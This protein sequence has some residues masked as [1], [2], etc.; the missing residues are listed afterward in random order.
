[1]TLVFSPYSP[2]DPDTKARHD[3]AYKTWVGSGIRIYP[4]IGGQTSREMGDPHALPFV[5]DLIWSAF[6]NHPD[7]IVIITNNDVRF[8]PNLVNAVEES[9]ER[10]GAYWAYRVNDAGSTDGGIDLFGFSRWW[11][12]LNWVVYPDMVIG[13]RAWDY[14]M[15]DIMV[16]SGVEEGV[17]AYYHTPHSNNHQQRLHT[18]GARWNEAL[19]NEWNQNKEST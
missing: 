11:W 4:Y 18:A 19:W 12:A 13:G 5:S 10:Q 9:C 7:N 15:K 17:R 6:Q 3:A 16:M 1:M 8:G 14:V 2:P